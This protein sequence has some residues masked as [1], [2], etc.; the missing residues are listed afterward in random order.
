MPGAGAGQA[1]PLSFAGERCVVMAT[2]Q[3]GCA[4]LVTEPSRQRAQGRQLG[5]LC[6]KPWGQSRRPALG[7]S[8]GHTVAASENSQ[9]SS[10]RLIWGGSQVLLRVQAAQC[11]AHTWGSLSVLSPGAQASPQAPRPVVGAHLRLAD[12]QAGASES[13]LLPLQVLSQTRP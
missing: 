3:G 4:R 5:V 8:P 11:S 10:V 13:E 2:P 6:I 12:L 7:V 9:P 1:V